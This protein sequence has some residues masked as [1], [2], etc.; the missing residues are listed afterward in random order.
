M[1]WV[2]TRK[3]YVETRRLRAEKSRFLDRYVATLALVVLAASNCIGGSGPSVITLRGPANP[4][5][6]GQSTTFTAFV[7]P[8]TATG[9]VTVYDGVF[10]VGV[11]QVFG[12]Q[13]TVVTTFLPPGRNVLH[14]FYSGDTNTLPATS[15]SIT[16]TVTGAAQN[17][18]QAA[19]SF[20]TGIDPVA[21]AVGDFNGDGKADLAVANSA[22]GSNNISVLLGKGD[23]SFA[24]AVSYPAHSGP[25]AVAVGDFNGDGKP[26][27]AVVNQSSDDVSILIGDGNGT[28][29]PPVDYATPAGPS[30]VMVTDVNG[31]GVEDLVVTTFSTVTILLGHGD[32]T[33]VPST[34]YTTTGIPNALAVG[35]LNGTAR[36]TSL[37][38][39]PTP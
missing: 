27:L 39:L 19:K 23:G 26:D 22:S 17:G 30:S 21:V 4:S 20:T 16:Q 10:V 2:A 7:G 32:G 12:G 5:T 31:D 15:T 36:S 24:T 13:A 9:T 25:T 35:D 29:Q 18:F 33:F 34:T 28:F 11:G 37:W 14:A 3:G 38:L 1:C 8:V 6:Y